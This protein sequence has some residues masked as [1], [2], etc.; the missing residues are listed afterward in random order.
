M[1]WNAVKFLKVAVPVVL[2]AALAFVAQPRNLSLFKDDH[3][4][5]LVFSARQIEAIR[6]AKRAGQRPSNHSSE[7]NPKHKQQPEVEDIVVI[8]N[9]VYDRNEVNLTAVQNAEKKVSVPKERNRTRSWPVALEPSDAAFLQRLDYSKYRPKDRNFLKK[10]AE[11]FVERARQVGRVCREAPKHMR[12]PEHSRFVWDLNHSPSI[13][14]C[15]NY[16]VASTTWLSNF[17]RLAHFNENNPAIP[18]NLPK[19]KREKMQLMAK[20]GAK[21]DVVFKLYPSPPSDAEKVKAMTESVRVTVVRHPFARLLSGYRDKMTKL[22][23]SPVKF[24]FRKTQ[25]EIIAKYRRPESNNTSTFPTFEEFVRYVID[26]TE[27]LV[28]AKDWERNVNCWVPYWAQCSVCANDYTLVMK[29]ETM[30]ED[31]QFLIALSKLKELKGKKS[32]SWKHLNV[33]L[34]RRRP[35]LLQGAHASSR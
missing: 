11:V 24:G 13:V 25:Q 14:F 18:D 4:V 23:P 35:G 17:L 29:L 5:T 31:E 22:R 2:L 10:R 20:Y 30:A 12:V 3:N 15:P 32:K 16:K 21:H 1:R 6:A 28:T 7:E 33:R 8:N 27:N 26:A 19:A 9:K 34:A